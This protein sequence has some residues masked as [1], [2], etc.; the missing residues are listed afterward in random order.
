[1]SEA[2]GI[3]LLLSVIGGFGT[4]YHKLGR[5]EGSVN[6]KLAEWT[7]LKEHCP[8]CKTLGLTKDETSDSE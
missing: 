5:L 1:M 8:L 6:G 7:Q 3:A 4:L 2:L